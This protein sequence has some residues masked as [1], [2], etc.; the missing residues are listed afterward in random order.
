MMWGSCYTPLE[1]ACAIVQLAE[2]GERL[3][4]TAGEHAHRRKRAG[5]NSTVCRS[6]CRGNM[7]APAKSWKVNRESTEM[8]GRV[9]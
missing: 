4:V 7:R 8:V 5:E 9:Q 3:N 1:A 6:G 2:E